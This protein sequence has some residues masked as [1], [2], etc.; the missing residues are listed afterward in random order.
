MNELIGYLFVFCKETSRKW[1]D[2][3]PELNVKFIKSL[4]KEFNSRLRLFKYIS[5][6]T[7]Q[8]HLGIETTAD[9]VESTTCIRYN[10]RKIHPVFDEIAD[11]R[12]IFHYEY[13]EKQK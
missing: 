11:E 4:A 1:N 12:I 6:E 7:I 3:Y 2:D 5:I 9:E 13:E 8:L 10:G